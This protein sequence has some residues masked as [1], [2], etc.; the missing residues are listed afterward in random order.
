M[1]SNEDTMTVI[2]IICK[3]RAYYNLAGQTA[4][5]CG[6]HRENGMV[7]VVSKRCK[8]D[9]CTSIFSGFNFP[10]ATTGLYC[11]T[12]GKAKGMVD[13]ISKTCKEDGC[14]KQPSFNFP[15]ETTGLYCVT[16]GEPKGMV[17]VISK[18]CKE[19]GCTSLHPNFNFRGE[20]AGLYCAKHGTPKGMVDVRHKT[21]KED[22]CTTRPSFNFPGKTTALYCATHGTPKGMVDVVHKTCEHDDECD[23]RPSYGYPGHAASFCSHHKKAGTMRHSKKR[24]S[25]SECKNW[26]THGI[27]KPE[28]CEAHQLPGD[29]NLVE[30]PCKNCNL[31]NLLSRDGLC[32]DCD[33]WFAKR[34]RLAKQRE[35]VQFLDC[36]MKDRPYA[37]VD[38]IPMDIRNCGGKERPDVL[39][40]LADR[41][42]ILEVDEDQHSGRPCECEQTRMMNISQALGCERNI[43]IRYNP[44]GFKGGESRK[45]E[46]ERGSEK[47]AGMGVCSGSAY[48]QHD[49]GDSFIFR[50]V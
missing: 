38:R 2:C 32:G 35:V 12:H 29:D 46:T 11:A 7:D 36:N 3:K 49:L 33:H 26:S 22:G 25:E 24:C 40:E 47:M 9:G 27:V 43:W 5:Y 30:K 10:G 37:S 14:T 4:R 17:N 1:T 18:T 23:T 19:D 8:E 28:R 50:W 45:W 6:E 31:V 44:D 48:S 34:P 21:C 41:I 20:K 39:W 16:H 42:V 15:G 13:V